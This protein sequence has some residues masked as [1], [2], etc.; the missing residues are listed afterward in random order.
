MK[1]I[2]KLPFILM[3]SPMVLLLIYFNWCYYGKAEDEI[4]MLRR[5]WV[6]E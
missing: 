5:L 2:L 4:N 3:V 6:D 1:L